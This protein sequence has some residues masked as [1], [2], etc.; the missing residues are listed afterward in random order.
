MRTY[1]RAAAAAGRLGDDTGMVVWCATCPAPRDN[2]PIRTAVEP[3]SVGDVGAWMCY[4]THLSRR[5]ER[6]SVQARSWRLAA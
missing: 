1:G 4:A 2:D 5:S 3:A 6:H